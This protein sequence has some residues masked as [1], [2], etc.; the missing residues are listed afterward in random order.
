MLHLAVIRRNHPKRKKSID[1]SS[2]IGLFLPG[3]K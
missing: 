1:V 3:L 2:E